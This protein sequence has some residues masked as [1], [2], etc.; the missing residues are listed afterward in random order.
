MW[1]VTEP[2]TIEFAHY[3]VKGMKW[4][5]RK[6]YEPVG[7]HRPSATSSGD[8]SR[9]DK[10]S[11]EIRRTTVRTRTVR[12][13]NGTTEIDV[14]GGTTTDTL[15]KTIKDASKKAGYLVDEKAKEVFDKL[16]KKTKEGSEEYERYAVNQN[17]PTPERLVN[18]FECSIA[19][20]MRHR[21]YDVQA[22]DKHGGLKIEYYN[23]F[24]VKDSFSVNST[25]AEEAY[26]QV[27]RECLLY[28]EGARGA[29]G[30]VWPTGSGHAINWEIK[31]GEFVLIDNQ[32]LGRDTYESF[33]RCDPAKVDVFRLDN[34]DVRP[35]VVNYIEN[36]NGDSEEELSEKKKEEE[37][38]QKQQ[39]EVE[40]RRK[41][42]EI[43]RREAKQKRQAM[44][45]Y[46]K[47]FRKEPTSEKIKKAVGKAADA[48]KKA[49]IV[50]AK[51]G[52]QTI[53]NTKNYISEGARFVKDLFSKR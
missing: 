30:L 22:N 53:N 5:V 45:N 25:S 43:Q 14:F 39:E 44:V 48:V 11:E 46:Y 15:T 42:M 6:E 3:G 16:P 19:T 52:K 2:D 4:G 7:K 23:A 34:A 47:Y 36:Y 24:D 51:I 9:Y 8:Y 1:T 26:N 13:Q 40:Q 29:I 49:G 31:N 33:L 12:N 20:E 38:K 18:C 28:G 37:R 35:E 27:A 17:G 32:Q 50:I 21:G 10:E 41:A